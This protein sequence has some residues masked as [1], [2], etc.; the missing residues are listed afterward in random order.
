MLDRLS[1]SVGDCTI[2]YKVWGWVST[3][4]IRAYNSRKKSNWDTAMDSDRNQN[5]YIWLHYGSKYRILSTFY[6]VYQKAQME[7]KC[8][9]TWSSYE[10][11]VWWIIK[12]W[13]GRSSTLFLNVWYGCGESW[14]VD[15]GVCGC[16]GADWVTLWCGGRVY[17]IFAT[18]FRRG[19]SVLDDG[20]KSLS[21]ARSSNEIDNLDVPRKKPPFSQCPE[22]YTSASLFSGSCSALSNVRTRV[23]SVEISTILS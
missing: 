15:C 10:K 20:P 6:Y 8:K 11:R 7:K 12:R 14:G 4:M 23:K 9:Y 5:Q 16:K 18:C 3:S 17:G 19:E 13:W 2:C 1:F 22:A 21:V